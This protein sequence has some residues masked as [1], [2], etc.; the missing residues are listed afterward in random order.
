MSELSD[1][2][3]INK[4]KG[5]DLNKETL[6][7]MGVSSEGYDRIM[8]P[9][10]EENRI[11][12]GKCYEELITEMKR[13]MDMPESHYKIVALWI[14]GTYLHQSFS[15]F[16]YLYF[17]AMKG[18][19]KTR[20]EGFIA[21][22]AYL[23]NGKKQSGITESVLFRSVPGATLVLD[24]MESIQTKDKA[25]LREY[26]NAAYKKGSTVD[27]TK[28]TK[29][30]EGENYVVETFQCYR[31]ICMANINGMN[32]VLGDRCLTL[33]LEKSDNPYQTKRIEDFSSNSK[34][35]EIKAN[36]L[37]VSVGLCII[38]QMGGYVTE[39]NKYIE[40]K[41]TTTQDTLYTEHTQA[42]LSY[43]ELF[44]KLDNSGITGRNLELIFPL[45]IIASL[46]NEDIL[47]DVLP[48]LLDISGTKK[49][50]EFSD[51]KDVS[52]IDYVSRADSLR[53]E[54]INIKDLCRRFRE[55]L[56]ETDD[57]EDRWLNPTWIGK[58]LKRL[59]LYTNKRRVARGS[60]VLLAVDRAKIKIQMFKSKD[61]K[62]E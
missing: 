2:W 60:E 46:L 10:L 4:T 27:R 57:N 19:G 51:D 29:T 11:V 21:H 25:V 49:D 35:L 17:N 28:K 7:V 34:L 16:P 3:T 40:D 12:F 38:L 39:W 48:I 22:V 37:K 31:P 36:L 50:D 56:G 8:N 54:H 20:L 44:R 18:S 15:S 32:D 1:A 9:D 43:I 24:E 5:L 47:N 62:D 61:E 13:Y 33:I 42:T 14:L 26:L 30:K 59:N 41:Y 55:W 52:L 53:F 6:M 23:A 58:S 45:T